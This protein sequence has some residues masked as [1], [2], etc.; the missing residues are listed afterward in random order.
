MSWWEG[1]NATEKREDQNAYK[2]KKQKYEDSIQIPKL[3]AGK[4]NMIISFV[5]EGG[6]VQ[7]CSWLVGYRFF[8]E[9]CL[10]TVMKL[11]TETGKNEGQADL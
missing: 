5:E 4:R 6:T 10:T 9:L 11:S 7:A 2:A 1:L 3:L 8:V